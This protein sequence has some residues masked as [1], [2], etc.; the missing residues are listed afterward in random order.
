MLRVDHPFCYVL[1]LVTP[2]LVGTKD[3]SGKKPESPLYVV[4]FI[5]REHGIIKKM[6]KDR[7]WLLLRLLY[8]VISSYAFQTWLR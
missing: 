6:A 7:D 5:G 3:I 4:S 1:F 2:A 8:P